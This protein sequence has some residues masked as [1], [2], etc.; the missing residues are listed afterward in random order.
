MTD[1]CSISFVFPVHNEEQLLAATAQ[2][3]VERLG[4]MPGSELIMVENG[5]T[6]GSPELTRTLARDLSSGAVAVRAAQCEKGMGNAWRTGIGLATADLIVLTAA[7]LPFDFSDL[8]AALAL[9]PRPS[10]VLGSKAHPDTYMEH[11]LMRRVMSWGFRVLR[12][13]MFESDVGDSQGTVLID[14]ALAQQL[15]PQLRSTGFFISTEIVVLAAD[16][17]FPPTEVPVV[18]R[19]SGR[20]STVRPFHDAWAMLQAMRE[21]RDRRKQ[22]GASSPRA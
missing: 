13:R 9:Q 11:T 19:P 16:A 18:Y 17:G 21:L 22:S 20:E 8:D 3:V 1:S 15:L 6:D 2:R 4:S 10:V 14:R 5:S 12:S 7:D